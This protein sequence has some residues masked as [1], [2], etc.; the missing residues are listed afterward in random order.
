MSLKSINI[1]TRPDFQLDSHPQE[2]QGKDIEVDRSVIAIRKDKS[3]FWEQRR[4][5][6]IDFDGQPAVYSIR[7]DIT[8]KIKTEQKLRRSE[9]RLSLLFDGFK[10]GIL[11]HRHRKAL[12]SNPA[13]AEMYGYD[14]PDEIL[15]LRTTLDLFSLKTERS[16]PIKKLALRGRPHRHMRNI[17]E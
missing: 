3:E 8:A 7:S 1:F 6:I 5:L 11:I 2:L 16:Q 12:F 10:Q 9:K 17:E 15:S 4:T 13:L 14:L